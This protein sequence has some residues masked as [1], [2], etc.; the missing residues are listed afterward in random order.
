MKLSSELASVYPVFHVS[1][2]KMFMGDPESK[3]PIESLC[4]KDNLP[5]QNVLVPIL[6]RHV[7]LR[8]IEVVPVKALWKNHLVKGTTLEA[9]NDM[10]SCYPH[11]FDNSG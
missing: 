8:D 1:M 7:K 3:L 11:L 5:Y 2:L 4:V 6:D 9:E 10:N